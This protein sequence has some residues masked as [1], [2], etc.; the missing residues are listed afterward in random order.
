M[1]FVFAE[2]KIA[3]F[4]EEFIPVVSIYGDT[5]IT[6]DDRFANKSDWGESTFE[7]EKSMAF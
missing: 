1:S 7:L 3:K 2:R 5:K 4:E 6:M